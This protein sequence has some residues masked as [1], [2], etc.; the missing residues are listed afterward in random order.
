MP[1]IQTKNKVST[2]KLL[3]ATANLSSQELE[4]FVSQAIV[5]RAKRN[6]PNI[7]KTEAE[8]LL[9]IN[10]GLSQK[11]QKRFD[12]LAEKLASETIMSDER[13]E[14]LKLTDKIEKQDAKRIEFLGELAEI[15]QITLNNL[16]HDLNIVQT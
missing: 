16:L 10:Q 8:L 7:P 5:L 12:E 1:N 14:F 15:R 4:N 11:Q 2:D 6:A 9:K 13:E 3:Q